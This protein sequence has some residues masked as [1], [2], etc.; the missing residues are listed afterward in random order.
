MI[1]KRLSFAL[2]YL[3]I[4]ITGPILLEYSVIPFFVEKYEDGYT[5]GVEIEFTTVK[6][7]YSI[8]DLDENGKIIY[9]DSQMLLEKTYV[10]T[11]DT[12]PEGFDFHLATTEKHDSGVKFRHLIDST[13]GW[14]GPFPNSFVISGEILI[15]IGSM[16]SALQTFMLTVKKIKPTE[17]ILYFYEIHYLVVKYSKTTILTI[18]HKL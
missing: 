7:I 8:N 10:Y 17:K 4:G 11:P 9:K 3:I 12:L 1:T 5:I 14:I 18:N 16:I 15:I 6:P 13:L 2:F